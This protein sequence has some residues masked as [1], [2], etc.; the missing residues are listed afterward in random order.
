MRQVISVLGAV[1]ILLPFAASQLGRLQTTA[2]AYQLLNLIGATAL[3][4]VAVLEHQYGFILL[5]ATWALV[6]LV[7]L[8]R[9]RSVSGADAA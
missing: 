9:V 3:T 1:C 7:G 6:S 2:L 8:I 4:V 5:E